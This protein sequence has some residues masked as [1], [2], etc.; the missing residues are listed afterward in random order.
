MKDIIEKQRFSRSFESSYQKRK[1][2][3]PT[4]RISRKIEPQFFEQDDLN[5]PKNSNDNVQDLQNFMVGALVNASI[6][7][8]VKSK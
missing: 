7:Q 5:I 2:T 1:N 3:Q 6:T 4:K 8:N